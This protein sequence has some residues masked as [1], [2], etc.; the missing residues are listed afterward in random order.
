MGPLSK[1]WVGVDE[2]KCSRKSGRMSL[3]DLSTAIEQTGVLVGQASQSI[4]YQRRHNVLTSLLRD[5]PKWSSILKEES[6]SLIEES[7]KL[8]GPKFEEHLHKKA[9][10]KTESKK[11]FSKVSY[12]KP[13]IT[14]P[15][16]Q[17]LDLMP[18]VGGDLS[19]S[20]GVHP[21]T[22][23]QKKS[24]YK[25]GND[26]SKILGKNLPQQFLKSDEKSASNTFS[27][28]YHKSGLRKSNNKKVVSTP[29]KKYTSGRQNN[30]LCIKLVKT[31]QRQGNSPD[32]ERSKNSISRKAKPKAT[33][34]RNKNVSGRGKISGHRSSGIVEEGGNNTCS[35]IRGSIFQQHFSETEKRRSFSPDYKF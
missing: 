34:G 26:I 17:A 25:K 12:N 22:P 23:P 35:S 28:I 14:S 19:H 16:H 9:K 4:T 27:R 6:G 33:F 3:E 21:A 29:R 15:F 18:E 1:L 13:A 5:P 24:G 8:F 7:N 32:R 10:L 20:S 11:L 31:D 30:Q 2:A